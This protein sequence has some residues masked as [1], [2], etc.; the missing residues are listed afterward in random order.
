MGRLSRDELDFPEYIDDAVV[1]VDDLTA[2]AD[3]TTAQFIFGEG[4][5]DDAVLTKKPWADVIASL[6]PVVVPTIASQAEAEA[7]ADN[8]KMMTALRTR[9]AIVAGRATFAAQLTRA[10]IPGG[11]FVS[12][13]SNIIVTGQR[14][15]YQPIF[16][17]RKI[18]V[19]GFAFRV[20]T[21]AANTPTYFIGIYT[22][23]PVNS[24]P[25][26][27][28]GSVSQAVVAATTYNLSFSPTVDLEPG[29]YMLAFL[30]DKTGTQ[31]V[32]MPMFEL[33]D[34]KDMVLVGTASSNPHVYGGNSTGITTLPSPNTDTINKYDSWGSN[35]TPGPN[36]N[37]RMPGYLKWTE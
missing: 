16:V 5:G 4:V 17:Q 3:P 36:F 9:Q 26:V 28:L 2:T 10:G 34:W 33:D 14:V 20:G 35:A 37:F 29:I 22:W 24:K 15:F 12:D 19:T 25:S 27:L 13:L 6:G 8:A 30:A 11:Y 18:T 32:N 21:T 7:G 1:N 31:N 23:D